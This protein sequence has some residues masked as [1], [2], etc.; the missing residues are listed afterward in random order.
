MAKF[1]NQNS[2]IIMDNAEPQPRKL[3]MNF[4]AQSF[5]R[6]KI[7]LHWA[8]LRAWLYFNNK[9]ENEKFFL[10][11]AQYCA[12]VN[13]ARADS[14]KAMGELAAMGY[15]IKNADGVWEFYADSQGAPSE[16]MD[17]FT[18]EEYVIVMDSGKPR[19]GETEPYIVIDM[20]S[21]WQACADL[22]K[23]AFYL[24]IYLCNNR[25][26]YRFD[27]G[28]TPIANLMGIGKHGYTLACKEL[29]EKGYLVQ[30]RAHLF[31]FYAT[32]E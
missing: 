16:Q 28:Y 13:I 10:C 26:N 20:D 5:W 27:L 32:K 3:Y 21:F 22:N 2:I 17:K 29:K 6:A 23:T 18:S 11:L 19:K 24:W 7:N 8:A 1:A 15:L 12:E 4:R 14:Y 30:E 25:I 31:Y 9:K